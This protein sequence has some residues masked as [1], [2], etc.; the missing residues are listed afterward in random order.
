LS[1]FINSTAVS[2]LLTYRDLL[3]TKTTGPQ[4]TEKA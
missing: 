2:S 1:D 3:R 4:D